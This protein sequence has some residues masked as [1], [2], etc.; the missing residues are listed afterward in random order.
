LRLGIHFCKS[1]L[2]SHSATCRPSCSVRGRAPWLR[3]GSESLLVTRES[4]DQLCYCSCGGGELNGAG[5]PGR[6]ECCKCRGGMEFVAQL[7]CVSQDGWAA[8]KGLKRD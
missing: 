4:F 2:D 3:C 8:D 5:E 7:A 1:G 6:G